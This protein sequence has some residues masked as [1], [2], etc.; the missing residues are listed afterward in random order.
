MRI[1]WISLFSSVIFAR[2]L[3][4]RAFCDEEREFISQMNKQIKQIQIS[5][6]AGYQ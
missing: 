1:Q 5:T 3:D 2:I 6:V 4:E